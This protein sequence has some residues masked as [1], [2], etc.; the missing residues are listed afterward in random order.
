MSLF[1]N[2]TYTAWLIFYIRTCLLYTDDYCHL[3]MFYVRFYV[4]TGPRVKQPVADELSCI[5]MF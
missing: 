1:K 5:N 3:F 4:M 2:L